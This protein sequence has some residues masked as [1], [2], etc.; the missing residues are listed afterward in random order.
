MAIS[1]S[2]R[3][4]TIGTPPQTAA[5]NSKLTLFFSANKESLS[6]YLEINALFAVTTCFLF[7]RASN[8]IFLAGPSSPP[9]SS[10]TRSTSFDFAASK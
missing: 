5:S 6:P 1:P 7:L 3:D 4:L 9:I 10:I 8:T 2:L